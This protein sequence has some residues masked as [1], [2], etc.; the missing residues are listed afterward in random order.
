MGDKGEK[1]LVVLPCFEGFY[2]CCLAWK[3][4]YKS[5]R[6]SSDW[7][8]LS[9]GEHLNFFYLFLIM[10]S[11]SLPPSTGHRGSLNGLMCRKCCKSYAIQSPDLNSNH[12]FL[13]K[14]YSDRFIIRIP[15]EGISFGRMAFILPVQFHRLAS[16]MF[17][18]G[19]A[20]PRW[21]SNLDT[22]GLYQ[23]GSGSGAYSWNTGRDNWV[24]SGY[25][26]SFF[27]INLSPIWLR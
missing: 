4:H 1:K 26:A 2:C 16:V 3:G 17:L 9:Y 21:S 19:S 14:V 5:I 10:T 13:E 24:H 11:W 6:S 7:S 27:S 20:V 18:D 25:D 15:V 12:H 8:P 23:C 22:L